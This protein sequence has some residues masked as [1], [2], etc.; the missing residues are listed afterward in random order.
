[1]ENKI[2]TEQKERILEESYAEG[3]II[4]ELARNHKVSAKTS[5]S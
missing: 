1:M 4:T 2:S 5:A 3:C